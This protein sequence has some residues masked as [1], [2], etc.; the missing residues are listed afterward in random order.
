MKR[1]VHETTV[2]QFHRS[3]LADTLVQG[4]VKAQK[5]PEL[6]KMDA[7]HIHFNK[8]RFLCFLHNRK[9]A[10]LFI[11]VVSACREALAEGFVSGGG[12]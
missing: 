9:R 11:S 2:Q 8:F 12:V 5:K 6:V 3:S 1:L 10:V 4:I 7:Q